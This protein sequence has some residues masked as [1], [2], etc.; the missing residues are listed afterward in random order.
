MQLCFHPEQALSFFWEKGFNEYRINITTIKLIN[1]NTCGQKRWKIL[2]SR[3][4][5]DFPYFSPFLII[6]NFR[7]ICIVGINLK[8]RVSS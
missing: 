8:E 6:N 4:G 7:K 3:T 5:I 1:I 2:K